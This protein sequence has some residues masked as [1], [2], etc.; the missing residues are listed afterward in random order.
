M[1]IKNFKNKKPNKKL[2]TKK[3][4]L[5]LI[6]QILF[7]NINY[8]FKLSLKQHIQLVFH[9]SLLEKTYPK[10]L[11]QTTFNHTNDENIEYKV[12]KIFNKKPGRYL[13][14]WKRHLESENT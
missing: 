4:R 1:H 14:K 9:I 6:K 3:I 2:N 11:L 5:F 10:I 12:K 8:Q 7:N 13:V